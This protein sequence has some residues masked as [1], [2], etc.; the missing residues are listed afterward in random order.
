MLSGNF[1]LCVFPCFQFI[2]NRLNNY[3]VHA[4]SVEEV[5]L[6]GENKVKVTFTVLQKFAEH[7]RQASKAQLVRPFIIGERV[8]EP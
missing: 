1:N 8:P 2:K 6:K 4:G 7:I 3:Y 5:E